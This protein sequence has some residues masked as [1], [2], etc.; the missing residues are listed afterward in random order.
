MSKFLDRLEQISRAAPAPMGFGAARA[1]K[2]PGMALIGIVSG[3]YAEGIGLLAGLGPDAVLVAGVDGPP[4][5]KELGQSLGS[6]IPWGAKVSS[7]SGEDAQ[8]YEEGGCGLL[9]FSLQGT[10]VAAVRSEEMARI[11][12]VDADIESDQLRAVDALPVD[13][14]LLSVPGRAAPWTLEDLAAVARVSRRV[15]KYVLLEVSQIPGAKELE[16]LR[17]IGVNGLVA[18]V[19]TA[20]AANL[21]ELKAALL[22]MP[23]QRFPRK[24]RATAILPGS[25]FSLGQTPAR[26]EPDPEP[27]EDE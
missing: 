17:N 15:D 21:A 19:T 1:Q 7:L 16:A 26:E 23:R 9:A 10:S 13:A 12:C 5:L 27:E 6:D 4:A 18:D 2:T 20:D 25:A 3:A 8:A 11:L 14:L 24:E 22:D